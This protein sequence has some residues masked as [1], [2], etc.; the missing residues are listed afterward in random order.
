MLACP[1]QHLGLLHAAFDALLSASPAQQLAE[2]GASDQSPEAAEAL[3]KVRAQ[4][5]SSM[6]EA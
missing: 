6:P 5:L 1:V 3:L 4:G 2:V